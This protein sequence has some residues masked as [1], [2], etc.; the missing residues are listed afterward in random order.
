MAG[1]LEQLEQH[2]YQFCLL[3]PEGD[4][5]NFAGALT[6]GTAKERPDPAGVLRVLES[7]ESSVVV[8]MIDIPVGDRP[9]YCA[10]L[11]PKVQDL[12]ARTAR[13]HWLIFDEAHH[14][15]PANWSPASS[16][17]PQALETTI[18]ITVHPDHVSRA[19]LKAVNVVL[20]T[21]KSPMQTLA[22]YAK[23]V[24][25]QAP[26]GEEV[27]LETGEALV[28][29]CSR[30][31][32]PIRVRTVPGKAERRR[33]LR[34]YAEGE[35]SDPQ[36]FYFRG[37]EGKLNLRAHNLNIFVQLA[38][39]VDEETWMY[40]LNRGDYS[41]WFREIIKDESLAQD[42]EGIESEDGISA[43]ESRR[44]IKEAIESRYT[45]AA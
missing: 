37:P 39:G 35:L 16:T 41:R 26:S 11:L 43:G 33:H 25:M 17:V 28:W 38:E 29:F 42:A 44:R 7:P 18:L 19:A 9:E 4:F 1:I 2:Q 13:P 14:L 20:V 24:E 8:N 31:E 3:D 27:E 40:H 6:L 32:G 34:Q 21:G 45:A 12:R 36:C 22:A 10:S 5:E 30:N 15:L 23:A